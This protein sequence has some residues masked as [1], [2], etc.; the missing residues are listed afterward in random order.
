MKAAG[1]VF[2]VSGGYVAAGAREDGGIIG[3]TP[4]SVSGCSSFAILRLS[5]SSSITYHP[6]GMGMACTVG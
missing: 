6:G 1:V 4:V 3:I 2:R 5:V